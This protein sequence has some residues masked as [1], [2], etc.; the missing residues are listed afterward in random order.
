MQNEQHELIVSVSPDSQSSQTLRRD[1][2]DD[3]VRRPS[4][5]VE[6]LTLEKEASG[7]QHRMMRD[8]R[9]AATRRADELEQEVRSLR[10]E[11]EEKNNEIDEKNNEIDEKNNEIDGLQQRVDTERQSKEALMRE[12][13][14]IQSELFEKDREVRH[15]SKQ[16]SDL[17]V[18]LSAEASVNAPVNLEGEIRISIRKVTLTDQI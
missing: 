16:K 1:L 6:Q 2:D 14:R 5:Q 8:E 10:E 13:E 12:K 18:L 15:L 17:E 7:E 3:L 11:I 4:S 9:D